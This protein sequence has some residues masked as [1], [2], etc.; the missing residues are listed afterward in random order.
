RLGT[1]LAV[2]PLVAA[3]CDA[4]PFVFSDLDRRAAGQGDRAGLRCLLAHCCPPVCRM[5]TCAAPGAP[6]AARPI[7]RGQ[8]RSGSIDDPILHEPLALV[9]GGASSRSTEASSCRGSL[10]PGVW[11]SAA[12]PKRCVYH[13][14]L[15]APCATQRSLTQLPGLSAHRRAHRDQLVGVG[16]SR[17]RTRGSRALDA[18]ASLLPPPP[19]TCPHP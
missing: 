3:L 16:E 8:A 4:G 17:A 10:R 5:T 9:K 15:S 1:V 18:M 6:V 11:S 14:A 7:A 13:G 12:T 19:R 2:P